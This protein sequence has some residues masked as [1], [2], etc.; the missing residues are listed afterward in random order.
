MAP[1]MS[2]TSK[3]KCVW[4]RPLHREPQRCAVLSNVTSCSYFPF[5]SWVRV[6]D[7]QLVFQLWQWYS[8]G[9]L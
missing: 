7:P 4:R 9:F 8:L 1:R 6:G 2:L 3:E 5:V